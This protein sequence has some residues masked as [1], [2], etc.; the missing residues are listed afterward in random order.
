MKISI[1]EDLCQGHGVC[2]GELPEVFELGEAYKVT[3]RTTEPPPELHDKVRTAAKYCP[4]RAI[5]IEE[6]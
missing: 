4:T 1:D 2:E 5:R 3:L 6:D